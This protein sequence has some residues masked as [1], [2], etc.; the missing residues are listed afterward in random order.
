LK[1]W[2][3]FKIPKPFSTIVVQFGNP[4]EVPTSLTKEEIPFLQETVGKA[5]NEQESK[6]EIFLDCLKH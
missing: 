6:A 5:I 4:I 1:T 2:D 3:Q